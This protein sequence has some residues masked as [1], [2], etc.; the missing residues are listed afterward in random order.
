[1]VDLLTS[2]RIY[3]PAQREATETHAFFRRKRDAVGR[4]Q[5]TTQ[6]W[7]KDYKKDWCASLYLQVFPEKIPAGRLGRNAALKRFSRGSRPSA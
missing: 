7:E 3:R 1:M 2:S 4:G 6:L 5:Q